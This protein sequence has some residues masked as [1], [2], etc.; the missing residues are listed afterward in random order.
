MRKFVKGMTLLFCAMAVS[1]FAKGTDVKAAGNATMLPDQSIQV[2][3]EYEE[4]VVTAG[5]NTVI[6]YADNANATIWEEA[7]VGADG[8]AIFDISWV[9]AGL[10]TRVY[11][12][13]DVDTLVTARY[14]NAEEKFSA[15]FVGDISAADVV[16]V[17]AWK[18]VY[19]NY[20]QFN[21]ETGYVLFFTKK[22][23]AVRRW[24]PAVR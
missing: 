20:P 4:M 7:E 21:S 14:I 1:V 17:E 8:K 22:G 9:K 12:K 24:A 11:L 3:Y 19:E 6:Y 18:D 10:T 5:N 2:N 15:E 23:G 13:G 16:D